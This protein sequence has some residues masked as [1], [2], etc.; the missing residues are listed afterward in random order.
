MV[1]SPRSASTTKRIRSFMGSVSVQG[2]STSRWTPYAVLPMFPVRSVPYVPGLYRLVCTP[3][4]LMAFDCLSLGA[5]DLRTQPLHERR[6]V[7]EDVVDAADLVFPVRRLAADGL[8]AWNV[9]KDRRYEG[10]VAKRGD[11][12]Y[13]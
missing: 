7:L 10:L 2:M 1:Y 5:R 4:L 11:S 8:D 12:P 13:V 3:P 6:R 9:V